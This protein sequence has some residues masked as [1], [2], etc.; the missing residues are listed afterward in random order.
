MSRMM[1]P[2]Q[3]VAVV[4]VEDRWLHF[5]FGGTR[6]RRMAC[7]GKEKLLEQQESPKPS[8]HS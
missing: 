8:R 1:I 2:V 6:V 4:E 3:A 7:L 5:G